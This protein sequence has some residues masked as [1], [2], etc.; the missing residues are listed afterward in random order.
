MIQERVNRKIVQA[1]Q[2]MGSGLKIECTNSRQRL[3][4]TR[5]GQEG[6]EKKIRI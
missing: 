6:C 4:D 2:Y 1:R 5:P 3:L